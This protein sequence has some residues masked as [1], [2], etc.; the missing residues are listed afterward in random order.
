MSVPVAVNSNSC[1]THPK[2]YLPYHSWWICMGYNITSHYFIKLHPPYSHNELNLN[3]P[4]HQ[5]F[6]IYY[7]I[8]PNAIDTASAT[9]HHYS[10]SQSLWSPGPSLSYRS[11][12]LRVSKPLVPRLQPQLPIITTQGLKAVAIP[13]GI[14]T[15]PTINAR[16]KTP[17][18]TNLW[19]EY[20]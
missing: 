8:I 19:L 14:D 16:N 10:G 3:S 7:C 9:D 13:M 12:L 20:T 15:H 1:P 18:S 6:S 11:S 4:S 5:K 2:L 17:N